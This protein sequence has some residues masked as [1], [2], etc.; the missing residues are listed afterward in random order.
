[1]HRQNYRF[2]CVL[3]SDHT[4]FLIPKSYPLQGDTIALF[5][6]VGPKLGPYAIKI[7]GKDAGTFNPQKENYAAQTALYHG[8]GLG[9]G[10]HTL[11]VINQPTSTDQFLAIDFALAVA[12]PSSSSSSA[13]LSSSASASASVSASASAGPKMRYRSF[14]FD[15]RPF[16]DVFNYC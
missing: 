12:V 1:M 11:E 14:H 8:D 15:V 2:P 13:S 6:P 4:V 10:D 5:G 9:A 7:D 16:A 3:I